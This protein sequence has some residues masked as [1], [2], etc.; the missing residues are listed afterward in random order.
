M[1][2]KSNIELQLDRIVHLVI[3]EDF[4]TASLI[5]RK[6]GITY[7]SAQAVLKK[8]AELGYIEKYKSFKKLKVIKQHFIQ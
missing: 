3:R 8:L 1:G 2:R 5:Q 7:P 6:L 4:V